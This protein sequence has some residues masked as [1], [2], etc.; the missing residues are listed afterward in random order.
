MRV[1]RSASRRDPNLSWVLSLDGAGDTARRL[2]A[3]GN[4][5]RFVS[6]Q[7]VDV[8]QRADRPSRQCA[9]SDTKIY[10][11]LLHGRFQG[12][13]C[14]AVRHEQT[15]QATQTTVTVELDVFK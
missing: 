4:A 7:H 1:R 2:A 15:N 10:A 12:S 11:R 5:E 13:S 14:R 8:R 3:M 6:A 9:F